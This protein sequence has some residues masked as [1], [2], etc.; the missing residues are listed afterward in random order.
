M[1]CYSTF[2][3]QNENLSQNPKYHVIQE[4]Q[5]SP[6]FFLIIDAWTSLSNRQPFS[7]G[8]QNCA[9]RPFDI[10]TFSSTFIL[11]M[12]M[13][14]IFITLLPVGYPGVV[15]LSKIQKIARREARREIHFQVFEW[16]REV[17]EWQTILN[18]PISVRFIHKVETIILQQK[19]AI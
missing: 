8:L 7:W 17:L 13:E 2:F 12:N 9:N 6:N 3:F 4:N 16:N 11:V 19:N 5:W 10:S 14:S 18:S 15:H 1:F